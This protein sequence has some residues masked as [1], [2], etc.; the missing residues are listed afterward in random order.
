MVDKKDTT[1]DNNN[2]GIWDQVCR[3]TN[4]NT[5][6]KLTFGK[7]ITSVQAQAQRK[8]A[9]E[10]F[11]PFGIGWGVKD[12]EY[13]EFGDIQKLNSGLIIHKAILWFK[14]EGEYGEFPISSSIEV[15]GRAYNKDKKEHYDTWDDECIKKVATDALTKGLSFLGFNSDI[16]EG[17]WDDNKY[18]NQIK[19]DFNEKQKEGTEKTG[20]T[21]E[22][23]TS[24]QKKGSTTPKQQPK[25]TAKKQ[26]PKDLAGF[27]KVAG[28][29]KKEIGDEIFMS[30]LGQM[31]FS[32][33]DEMASK[34]DQD[35]FMKNI[36]K[37]DIAC[38]TCGDVKP[39]WCLGKCEHREGETGQCDRWGN[40]KKK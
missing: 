1:K 15:K 40:K 6:K 11:G 28:A 5:V 34:I 22:S 25:S 2:M 17:M 39:S 32:S 23:T 4:P 19:K 3:T 24:N 31:G 37:H 16:F 36:N 14:W 18:V 20:N 9:T 30:E 21:G 7:K 35:K 29:I 33:L 38:S 27:E 13:I 8:R 12:H 26:P 10:V